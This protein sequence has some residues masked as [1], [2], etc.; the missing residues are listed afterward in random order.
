[1]LFWKSHL[2][3][4]V[5]MCV[6]SQS[7]RECKN[8]QV[9]SSNCFLTILD[10]QFLVFT[11]LPFLG[12]H[13]LCLYILWT[14]WIDLIELKKVIIKKKKHSLLSGVCFSRI[15]GILNN[16]FVHTLFSLGLIQFLQWFQTAV[17]VK[18]KVYLKSLEIQHH[19]T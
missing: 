14:E 8:L 3:L 5:C 6:W 10:K 13:M 17:V 18:T 15:T 16:Q 7:S 2:Y 12:I 1:M 19:I 4:R 9:I 11:W